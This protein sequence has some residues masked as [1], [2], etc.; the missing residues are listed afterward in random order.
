MQ[1]YLS[2]HVKAYK[3]NFI[4]LN[5]RDDKTDADSNGSRN[6][7]CLIDDIHSSLEK[8]N[9]RK[10]FSTFRLHFSRRGRTKSSHLS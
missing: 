5:P 1:G 6:V 8:N 3:W 2:Q 10:N 4:K 9:F 7:M